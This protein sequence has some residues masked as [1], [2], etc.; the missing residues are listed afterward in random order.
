MIG[1][2]FASIGGLIGA[3]IF[4]LMQDWLANHIKAKRAI[5]QFK[6]D[7][8]T[9][10]VT[11]SDTPSVPPSARFLPRRYSMSRMKPNALL[12][13]IAP[14]GGSIHIFVWIVTI[15]AAN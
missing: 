11:A 13:G 15:R 14:Q 10:I 12:I 2:V 3:G 8:I 1:L 6:A 5:I 7:G 9:T 4:K